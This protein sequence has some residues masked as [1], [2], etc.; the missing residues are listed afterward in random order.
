[1]GSEAR[2]PARNRLLA[3]APA[4]RQAGCPSPWPSAEQ[5]E[6]SSEPP[7]FEFVRCLASRCF[8]LPGVRCPRR[9]RAARG[10]PPGRLPGRPPPCPPNS[11]PWLP[12]WSADAPASSICVMRPA[13]PVMSHTSLFAIS[14]PAGALSIMGNC[15]ASNLSPCF[16]AG[17]GPD[18]ARPLQRRGPPPACASGLSLKEDGMWWWG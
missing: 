15:T 17:G 13:V 2:V 7:P 9:R 14:S 3:A 12:P 10:R 4:G 5:T 16:D 11:P 1:M 6:V 18:Q 8:P